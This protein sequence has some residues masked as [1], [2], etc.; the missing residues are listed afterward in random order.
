M[1]RGATS[2]LLQREGTLE[3]GRALAILSQ[4]ASALDAAHRRGLVHRD[5]KPANVLLDEDE[6]AYLTDFGVSK[7]LGDDTGEVAGTLEYLAPEQIRGEAVDGRTDGYSLACVLYECLAGAPPFRR[8]T[9]AETLWAHLREA[10]PPFEADPKLNPVLHR[11]LAQEP[12]ERYLTCAA[13]IAAARE[14]TDAAAPMLAR[15]H[16][17]LL[18]AGFVV[19]AAA[20]TAALLAKTPGGEGGAAAKAPAGNGVAAIG[21]ESEQLSAFVETAAAPSNIAVGEGAVWFLNAADD[22][23]AR[24]DPETKAITG[25]RIRSL[26]VPTDLAAGEGAVW[27]GTGSGQGGNWTD[28]VYRVDPRT[29]QITNAVQLPGEA[30]GGDRRYLN[31]GFPQIAVGAGG[32]WATGGGAVARIDPG[33]GRLVATIA[34]DAYRI[35]AG[36]EGVWYLSPKHSGAVTPIDPRTNRALPP[37]SV[38]DAS[39][40]GIAV[41]GG[42]VWVTAQREGVVWRITPGASPVTTP[43]EVGSGA[44]YVAY[45]AGALWVAN[46]LDGTV[47]RVDPVTNTVAATTPVGA[48]Q[49]LAAGAGSAWVSTVG[50]TRAGTLPVAACDVV[51]PGAP[52]DVLIASD[53]P[54]Q[55]TTDPVPRAMADAIR[56][57][58]SE[59]GFR[60]GKYSVGYRSCDD[61]SR[62]AAAFERR[63]CTANA[64][65]YA[66]VD[67]LVAVIGPYNSDCAE[68]E[69]PIL[70]RAAGGPLAVI[71]PSTGVVG[72]TREGVPPPDGYLGTPEIFYPIGTR[73]FVRLTSPES[74]WGAAFAMLSKRLA[75]KRVYVIDDGS[76]Y[77]RTVLSDPFRQVARKLGV[78]IAGTA[79]LDPEAQSVAGL[80]DR[81][82]RSGAQGVLLGAPPWGAALDLVKAVR[83]R[84]GTRAPIM[85]GDQFASIGTDKL[86]DAVGPGLRGVYAAT[87][88]VPR[89][90]EPLTAAA[91]RVA[92]DVDAQQRFVLE[93]A[94]ATELVLAAIAG[95]DGTRASVLARLRA[96]T[97]SDGILGSFRFDRNG[98]MTPGWVAILR[99]THPEAATLKQ[100]SDATF[101]RAVRVPPSILD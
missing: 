61:S 62:Q 34:A 47:V 53:L 90:L 32:V 59:H 28:T 14:V 35:A 42:S 52:A 71:S 8:Q 86:F 20:L 70:N 49:S 39:L 57:V 69:L 93:A 1:C 38:G 22:T 72:L 58:L 87:S 68:V 79:T 25:G 54:F 21:P 84:L 65:A 46:S 91:R 64:N 15:R 94:Q 56:A 97:V 100:H 77:W 13:L 96:S 36:R 45:G 81:V 43:I 18:A 10:P 26:S 23:V 44:N 9:P 3:P 30:T 76:G 6:H 80:A 33:T 5:V 82:A 29:D 31:G 83:A 74:L 17:V 48:V 75:L 101:Y 85:V 55:D 2:T 12:G 95:S 11:G 41:G 24:V 4:V 66:N 63:R 78:R 67:R 92:S 51:A 7:H 98:D 73:H 16:R 60:A 50:A 99:F 37:I 40:S 27:L 19:L 88:D 89:T